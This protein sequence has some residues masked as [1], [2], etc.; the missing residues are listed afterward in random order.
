MFGAR[1]CSDME[2]DGVSWAS[3]LFGTVGCFT[4]KCFFRILSLGPIPTHIAFILDGNRRYAQKWNLKEGDGHKAGFLALM[5]LVKYCYEMGFEYT[6]IFAFSIDSFRRRP[7][8]VQYVMDLMLEKI[9]G[10]LREESILTE[11]G[12]RVCFIGN[13]KLLNQA[14]RVAAEK[15]MMATVNNTKAVLLICVAYTSS[16]E[17]THAVEESCKEKWAKIQALNASRAFNG[18]TQL[19]ELEG[20]GEKQEQQ[21]PII[22]LTDLEKHMYMG[23]A[24]DRD[25]L[26]RTSGVTHLSNFL[27]WQTTNCIL[28]SP[29]A[30][31]P[32]A[33]QPVYPAKLPIQIWV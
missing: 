16:D 9:E 11:Y 32:E 28:Y 2:R 20:S 17:I 24:P 8:E 26:F 5:S 10:M 23:V 18:M 14:A 7:D 1:F 29:A 6:T 3:R 13:L 31:W 33:D 25:I 22:K 12:V 21:H 30:L 19:V 15:A 27:L 4:R